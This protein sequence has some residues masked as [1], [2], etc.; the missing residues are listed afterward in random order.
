[1]GTKSGDEYA[2]E[3]GPQNHIIHRK[4]ENLK[5]GTHLKIGD[6]YAKENGLDCHCHMVH[7]ITDWMQT[8]TK[9]LTR[10]RKALNLPLKYMNLV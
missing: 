6:K 9:R 5:N 1:M 8:V 7:W 3:N 2:K 10:A 4:T